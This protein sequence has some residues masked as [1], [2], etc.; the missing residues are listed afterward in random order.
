M[1]GVPV[2]YSSLYR[3]ARATSGFGTPVITVRMA[4]RPPG[5]VAEDRFRES[6][7]STITRKRGILDVSANLAWPPRLALEGIAFSGDA[8]VLAELIEVVGE[9]ASRAGRDPG[10]RRDHRPPADQRRPAGPHIPAQPGGR[11]STAVGRQ[12]NTLS[13]SG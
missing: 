6:P 4:D 1:R 13:S 9:T 11:Q 3:F 7:A 12:F 2:S 5:E 8:E 10:R